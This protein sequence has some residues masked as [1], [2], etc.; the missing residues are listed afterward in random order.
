LPVALLFVNPEALRF[1]GEVKP[2]AVDLGLAALLLSLALDPGKKSLLFWGVTGVVVTWAS[3]PAVFVLAGVGLA[4]LLCT[5]GPAP[6][7]A[8]VTKRIFTPD[9]LRW[10]AVGAAWLLSFALL[11]VF[12]LR[13][14]VNNDYLHDYHARWFLPFP[15]LNYPWARLTTILQ[16]MPKVAFGF[17]ALAIFFGLATA[18][19]GFLRADLDRRLLLTVP[20]ISAILASAFGFYSLMPRLLLFTLPAWWL[21]AALGSQRVYAQAK[22]AR[23]WRYIFIAVWLFVL[24]GTNVV[25]YYWSPMTFSDSR[26]LVTGIEPGY[27][28]LPHT[29]ALPA[30]D[31]YLRIHP[32]GGATLDPPAVDYLKYQSP[33][34]RYVGLYDVLTAAGYRERMEKD[35]IWAAE[36][37]CRV[38]TEA[39]FR[40][41]R[42]YYD[43]P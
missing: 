3:L 18:V 33:P 8:S 5:S 11:Y 39:M 42:V 31:Y 43:C 14:S 15:R 1:V 4:N 36:H 16:G 37:G 29:S 2:Y 10:L 21:L 34:G 40:A 19:I 12:V 23:Y 32:A 28:V 24:G 7:Q 20:L 13:P 26:R 17:T 30:Y 35:S 25:R 27:K 22:L 6:Q 9:R 38:R 41:A